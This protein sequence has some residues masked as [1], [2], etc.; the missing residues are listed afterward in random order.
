M[1]TLD[2]DLGEKKYVTATVRTENENDVVII[3]NE[4]TKWE[5]YKSVTA[6]PIASGS[7]LV[8]GDEVS[9]LI[10]TTEKGNF[11]LK[12]TVAI[13]PEVIIEKCVIKVS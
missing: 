6:D 1:V 8:T 3:N 9:A 12:F 13:G 10:E 2:F 5:L 4:K 11:V 7:C